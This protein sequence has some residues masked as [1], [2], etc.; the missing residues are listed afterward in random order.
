MPDLTHD[1]FQY[2]FTECV[3]PTASPTSTDSL[4][5]SFQGDALAGTYVFDGGGSIPGQSTLDSSYFYM[6]KPSKY[7]IIYPGVGINEKKNQAGMSVLQNIPNPFTDQTHVDV[8][9]TRPGNLSLEVFSL[10]GQKVTEINKGTVSSGNY[11]FA[12]N[13]SQ[14]S[15]GVY[16]YTVKCNNETSTHKMIVE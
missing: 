9:L 11:R 14:F 15:K 8:I 13:S 6:I 1:F 3:Y 2:H 12:L 10:T 4:Y 7:D 5:I 16:F